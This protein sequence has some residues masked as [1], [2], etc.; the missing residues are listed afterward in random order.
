[1]QQLDIRAAYL[2]YVDA[3][4][5]TFGHDRTKTIG[6]SEIMACARKVAYSK[7]GA[8][9]D[10]E[11]VDANGFATRGNHME[12]WIAG[13]MTHAVE[14]AGGQLLY[15]GQSNQITL[16][17]DPVSVTPDGVAV[18]LPRDWL[19]PHGVADLGEGC[20]VVTE[21]KSISPRFKVEKLP[22]MQHVYQCKLQL[23]MVRHA[24]EHRPEYGIVVYVNSDQ[25]DDIR[26]FA[27]K[28][29][30]ND[31]RALVGRAK[32]IMAIRDPNQAA[33]E[34]KVAGGDDCRVCPYA[35]QCLGFLP[36]LQPFEV[37]PSDKGALKRIKTLAAK[38]AAAERAIAKAKKI[39]GEA[40]EALYAAL[41]EAK[42]RYVKHGKVLVQAKETPSQ[43]RTD[44]NR[45]RELAKS[46]G[47]TDEQIE[48]CKVPTKPGAS[49]TVEIAT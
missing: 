19:A 14:A 17:A 12:A 49:L 41:A 37:T 46:L 7:T 39:D 30:E 33:P 15:A 27:V 4:K 5:T 42:T 24:T 45:L 3:T 18:E 9:P 34:G 36:W 21:F 31:F 40:E 47:A 16:I 13:W 35:K 29:D 6:A 26:V 28:H 25:Y 8:T 10:P 48:A 23:G 2:A 22:K 1:M 43:R 11:Y 32:R 44:A 20:C 38:K